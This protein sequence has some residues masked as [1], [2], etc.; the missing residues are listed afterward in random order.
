MDSKLTL[1]LNSRSINRAKHYIGKHKNNSLSKLVESYF[2]SLTSNE[3]S[4]LPAKLPPI[5]SSLAG[6]IQKRVKTNIEAEYTDYL[7]EKYK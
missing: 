7:M 4:P 3:E 6:I 2:D 5:V 1:K